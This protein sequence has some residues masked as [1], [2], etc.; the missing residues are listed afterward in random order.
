MLP[1][2]SSI[3]W[4]GQATIQ[5]CIMHVS[6]ARDWQVVGFALVAVIGKKCAQSSAVDRCWTLWLHA[7]VHFLSTVMP[8]R[9]LEYSIEFVKQVFRT[10]G[11]LYWWKSHKSIL[12]SGRKDTHGK[13]GMHNS[14]HLSLLTPWT[15]PGQKSA[16]RFWYESSLRKKIMVKLNWDPH[17]GWKRFAV[18]LDLASH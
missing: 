17:E 14:T 15:V 1:E 7:T 11:C 3:A 9:I 12:E 4:Q 8:E 5:P 18:K 13:E 16:I 2:V 6:K 10:R